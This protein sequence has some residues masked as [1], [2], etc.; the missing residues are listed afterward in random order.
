VV[1]WEY[2]EAFLDTVRLAP[3]RIDAVVEAAVL[4]ATAD[5]P[6]GMEESVLVQQIESRLRARS[7]EGEQADAPVVVDLDAMAVRPPEPLTEGLPAPEDVARPHRAA[8]RTRRDPGRTEPVRGAH[9]ATIGDGDVQ[10]LTELLDRLVSVLT[11]RAGLDRASRRPRADTL[12]ALLEET[13]TIN[14][15]TAVEARFVV[16]ICG[17]AACGESLSVVKCQAARQVGEELLAQLE[18]D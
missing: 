18:A 6:M 3:D 17:R 9:G 15:D 10:R 5:G 14:R 2:F 13:G 16:N 11:R 8:V 4:V 1:A 7:G 12:V